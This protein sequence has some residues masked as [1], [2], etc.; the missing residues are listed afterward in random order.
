MHYSIHD[1]G[2]PNGLFDKETKNSEPEPYRF[3]RNWDDSG[4]FV[5]ALLAPFIS[6]HNPLLTD[7]DLKFVPPMV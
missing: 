3:R 1:C 2:A 5:P 4:A 6:P 7:P